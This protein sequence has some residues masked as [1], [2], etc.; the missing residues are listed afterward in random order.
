MG[1]KERGPNFSGSRETHA[2]RPMKTA[3]VALRIKEVRPCPI[4]L[5]S[6]K[7]AGQRMLKRRT[8]ISEGSASTQN[9]RS[10]LK[11]RFLLKT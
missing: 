4:L 10:N 5:V 11:R 7:A 1:I 8:G 9:G 2:Q 6:P 3:K